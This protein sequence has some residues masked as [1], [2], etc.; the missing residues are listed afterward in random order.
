MT[1]PTHR[2]AVGSVL[3]RDPSPRDESSSA[4]EGAGSDRA[5][6]GPIWSS[7]LI[8]SFAMATLFSFVAAGH[9]RAGAVAQ[10]PGEAAVVREDRPGPSSG[11]VPPAA[12]LKR[13]PPPDGT[14][15]ADAEVADARRVTDTALGAARG[16]AVRDGKV[17]AYGDDYGGSPRMGVI[18]EYDRNLTPTGRQ[19]KLGRGGKPLIVHPTGLTWDRRLG[20]FLGDTVLKKAVISRLDWDRA[21]ADGTLDQAVLDTIEDDAAINGCRPTLVEVGDRPPMSIRLVARRGSRP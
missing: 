19:V 5:S 17:Y 16:I 3:R 2:R 15:M 14:W 13:Q 21:W 1:E 8:V 7:R 12:I 20:T 6:P 11:Q 4:D 18:R 10:S 9:P